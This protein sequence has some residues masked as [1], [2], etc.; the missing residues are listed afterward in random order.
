MLQYF[1]KNSNRKNNWIQLLWGCLKHS[2]F[3]QAEVDGILQEFF[4]NSDQKNSWKQSLHWDTQLIPNSAHVC[5]IWLGDS[6]NPFFLPKVTQNG[7]FFG[8]FAKAFSTVWFI[9]FAKNWSASK[10]KYDYVH[11][12]I[13]TLFWTL[14]SFKYKLRT[15]VNHINYYILFFLLDWKKKYFK[16]CKRK[17]LEISSK[18]EMVI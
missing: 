13:V 10:V 15:L 3:C 7:L 16:V 8:W 1:F 17:S 18:L 12:T 4:D 14:S 6:S 5:N 11:R 9:V 2:K